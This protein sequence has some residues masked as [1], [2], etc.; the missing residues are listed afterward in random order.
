MR[1]TD[2]L[3]IDE[4][5]IEERFIRAS[6][7]GGQHVN[8]TDSAVQ[9]RFDVE[10]CAA[11]APDVKARLKR[12]AGSR[13][14]KDGVLVIRADTQRARERNRADARSRLR[15]LIER[16]LIAPKPRKKSRPSL[17][18]VRRAKEA[19]ARISAKKTARK[20]PSSED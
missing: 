6:G 7:P 17:A 18:A 9:L 16:A 4:A 1:I 3:V 13:L 2:E 15:T 11:L 8:T 20:K 10:A 19:K 14:T 12:L 5:E